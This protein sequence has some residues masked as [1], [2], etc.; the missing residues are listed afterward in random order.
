MSS[1]GL[2][3]SVERFGGSVCGTV[4][5]EVEDVLIV[6]VNRLEPSCQFCVGHALD[7]CLG[8]DQ[9]QFVRQGVCLGD[10]GVYVEQEPRPGLLRLR[11]FL[12]GLEEEISTAKEELLEGVAVG[13]ELW[14][15]LLSGEFSPPYLL[16]L[17][18]HGIPPEPDPQLLDRV[19][20]QLLYMETVDDFHRVRERKPAYP[21]H[22]PS[23]VKGHFHDMLTHSHRDTLQGLEDDAGVRPG[24]YRDYRSLA[25]F[26]RLVRDDSVQLPVGQARLVN[27][28]PLPDVLRK[29]EPSVGVLPFRPSGV[30]AQVFLVLPL[31]LISVYVVWT[32]KTPVLKGFFII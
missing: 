12:R 10:V 25:P 16:V 28:Q 19:K 1:E 15:V 5:K 31:E 2:Y 13:E 9:P 7:F 29:D 22:R 4:V 32:L 21:P 24:D 23:H 8:V 17:P 30:A 20:S 18:V 27:A 6:V 3:L 11:P 14:P 26:G